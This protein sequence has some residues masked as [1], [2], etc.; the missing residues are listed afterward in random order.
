MAV[1]ACASR[2]KLYERR[3]SILTSCGWLGVGL[4]FGLGFGLGLGS[5]LTLTL[6]LAC[7]WLR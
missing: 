6:T 5:G 4:G 7:G 3:E 1:G 2:L